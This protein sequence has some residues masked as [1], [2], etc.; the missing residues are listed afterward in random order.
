VV[1]RTSAVWLAPGTTLVA[2]PMKVSSFSMCR[3]PAP[4]PALPDVTAAKIPARVAPALARAKPP[5]TSALL[6]FTTVTDNV[7]VENSLGI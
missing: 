6:S 5:S 1:S 4:E 3:K 7:P 2:P